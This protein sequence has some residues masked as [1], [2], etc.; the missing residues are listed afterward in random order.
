MWLGYTDESGNTGSNL[1]DQD[2]PLHWMLTVGVPEDQVRALTLALD[3]VVTTVGGRPSH[4][5]LHGSDLFGG[6]RDWAGVAPEVR[7]SVYRE[8][9]AL[10]QVHDCF[11]AHASIDKMKMA[12]TSSM[13][14]APHIMAFQFLSEKLDAYVGSLQDPLRQRI[15]LIADETDEHGVFQADLISQMQRQVA[16]IGRGRTLLNV[17]DTVHF[18]DSKRNRGVQLADLAA[19]A[20]NRARRVQAKPRRSQGDEAIV[21][22]VER[23]VAPR[24]RTYRETWPR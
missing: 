15:M 7:V 18:V 20:V 4:A 23:Y 11:V 17:V 6:S 1:R 9:L 8:A 2:Q 10:L 12:G 13:A 21:E 22:M 5:E 16:G 24:V 14:T 19:Y 3:G